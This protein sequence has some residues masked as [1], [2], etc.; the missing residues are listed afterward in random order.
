MPSM[1]AALYNQHSL[2]PLAIIESLTL[3][4]VFSRI[5]VISPADFYRARRCS[6]IS[7]P[8]AIRISQN[9]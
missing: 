5:P 7:S 6:D 4:S 1:V 9:K 3:R 2:P 8:Y